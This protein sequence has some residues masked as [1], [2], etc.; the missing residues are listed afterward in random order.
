MQRMLRHAQP[1]VTK[2]RYIKAFDPAVVEAM[3]RLQATVDSAGVSSNWPAGTEPRY[4]V[5]C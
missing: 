5:N 1:H 2:E 4:V 3:E